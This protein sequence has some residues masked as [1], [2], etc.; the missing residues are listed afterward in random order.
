MEICIKNWIN[1]LLV[2]WQFIE[3]ILFPPKYRKFR[4]NVH[5]RKPRKCGC[6]G[7]KWRNEGK[8][9]W[10]NG[11]KSPITQFRQVY[12]FYR[13][14][15]PL[16]HC[17]TAKKTHRK[18]DSKTADFSFFCGEKGI[19]ASLNKMSVVSHDSLTAVLPEIWSASRTILESSTDILRTIEDQFLEYGHFTDNFFFVENMLKTEFRP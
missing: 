4:L 19:L 16:P 11:K 3:N 9:G 6:G 17:G 2:T 13:N 15:L 18:Q 14:F 10:K 1:R 8:K 5:I 7:K 12:R